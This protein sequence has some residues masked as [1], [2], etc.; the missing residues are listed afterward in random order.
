MK[1]SSLVL[2]LLVGSS[3]LLQGCAVNPGG[4][5][6]NNKIPMLSQELIEGYQ[7]TVEHGAVIEVFRDNYD[8]GKLCYDT[9]MI[10]DE[11]V[12]RLASAS[13]ARFNVKPGTYKITVGL[14]WEGQGTCG[15]TKETFNEKAK[16]IDLTV[17][18]GKVYPVSYMKS[19]GMKSAAG[20][21]LIGGAVGMSLVSEAS[22][23]FDYILFADARGLPTDEYDA[24][25]SRNLL[26][27]GKF[28][29]EYLDLLEPGENKA[30]VHVQN[31]AQA[32]QEY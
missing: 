23:D 22:Q 2:C 8:A 24:T 7:E 13:K 11:R 5:T 28:K 20:L 18:E 27:V 26:F 6:S 30:T 19:L 10:N 4:L 14:D 3:V 17:E 1:L 25:G 32:V 21:Y 16:S 12:A 9:I 29:Q 15:C 31:Q